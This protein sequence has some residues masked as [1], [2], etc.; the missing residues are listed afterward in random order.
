MLMEK[1]TPTSPGNQGEHTYLGI[2][3]E[4]GDHQVEV[5][6]AKSKSATAFKRLCEV[7]MYG[8]TPAPHFFSVVDPPAALQIADTSTISMTAGG[9]TSRNRCAFC[10]RK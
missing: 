4:M 9:F 6:R 7:L 8:G 2:S 1:G 3:I 5:N 10:F